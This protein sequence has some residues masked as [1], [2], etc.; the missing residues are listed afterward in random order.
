MLISTENEN[1][2]FSYSKYDHQL[3]YGRTFFTTVRKRLEWSNLFLT[4]IQYIPMYTHGYVFTIGTIMLI[5]KHQ[6]WLLK[7]L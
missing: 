7:T 5:T 3:N 2:G 1:S 6:V 4:V